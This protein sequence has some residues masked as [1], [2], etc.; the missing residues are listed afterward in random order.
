MAC[1]ETKTFIDGTV[2]HTWYLEEPSWQL[3]EMCIQEGLPATCE[4]KAESRKR[5]LLGERLLLKH[6][7]GI[8]VELEH[9]DDLVPCVDGWQGFLSVAH[10]RSFLCIATHLEHAMGVD[11]ES[12]GRRVLNVRDGFLNAGE[13]TWLSLDDELG[14][15][16]AWTAKEAI[17]KAIGERKRVSNYREDIVLE[18]FVTPRV[19]ER[20]LWY[21]AFGP[22][23]F[24]LESDL[25]EHF[26][27][28]FAC[29][30]RYFLE[31]GI[32]IDK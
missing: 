24:L 21:G 2:L 13:K 32:T 16:I 11:V 17:F 18:P 7:F 20:L 10:T 30:H 9:N 15:L 28:T 25:G 23:E 12:Y 29:A 14:H 8:P 1:G 26:L 31:N 3:A 19:G 6:I 27:L 5:E 22:E 4:A